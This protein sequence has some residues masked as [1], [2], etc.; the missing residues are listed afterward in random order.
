M[1]RA[2][3]GAGV[4]DGVA[5]IVAVADRDIVAVPHAE[6]LAEMLADCDCVHDS[7]GENE[8]EDDAHAD[9]KPDAV[10]CIV[11]DFDQDHSP[12]LVTETV[13]ESEGV[14]DGQ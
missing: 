5:V 13:F 7:V 2:T 10:P 12:V 14:V 6:L 11:S 9:E 8:T 3:C 4:F 1:L